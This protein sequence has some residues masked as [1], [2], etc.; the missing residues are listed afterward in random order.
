MS[1]RPCKL[2]GCA[3]FYHFKCVHIIPRHSEANYQREIDSTQSIDIESVINHAMTKQFDKQKGKKDQ[4]SFSENKI[5]IRCNID[6]VHLFDV[7]LSLLSVKILIS[8]HSELE[9]KNYLY[10]NM[11]NPKL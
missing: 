9:K 6:R 7:T 10:L 11:H 3:L 5:K 8:R 1:Y 2:D 4:M